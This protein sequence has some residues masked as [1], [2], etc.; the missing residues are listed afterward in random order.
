MGDLRRD[1]FQRHGKTDARG[2]VGSALGRRAKAAGGGRQAMG[3]QGLPKLRHL[4]R[5]A[6]GRGEFVDLAAR[7]LAI[8]GQRAHGADG[9]GQ[10]LQIGEAHLVL[11][12]EGVRPQRIG[13]SAEGDHGLVGLRQ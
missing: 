4:Q 9:L 7:A 3:R 12:L 5:A 1:E 2:H 6:T 13:H 8:K 11:K 10:A